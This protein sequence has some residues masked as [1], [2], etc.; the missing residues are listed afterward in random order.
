VSILDGARRVLFVHAHPDDETLATG[1]LIAELVAR[2][3]QVDLLTATRGERGEIV[4]GVLDHEPDAET[5]A[6]IRESELGAATDILGIERRFWLGTAP[7]RVPG[8]APVVYVDSGMSWVRPG[9]AGPAPDV[10]AGALVRAPFDEVT[11]DVAALIASIRPSLVVGYDHGGGYG[12]PDHVRM[13]EAA[14]AACRRTGVALAEIV[15]EPGEGVEWFDLPN[16]LQTVTRALR[17]HA[18][19]LRVEGSELVH[20]GGQRQ[21]IPVSVGLRTTATVRDE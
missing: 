14:A 11:A 12:H 15:D 16:Q 17:A 19:Q 1:A 20:S 8:L 18:T 6:R 9:L 7:A 10:T 2:G 5:L 3:V 4:D 21:P 13:H